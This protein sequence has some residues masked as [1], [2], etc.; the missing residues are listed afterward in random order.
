MEQGYKW[1]PYKIVTV[2]TSINGEI[3]WYKNK[4]KNFLLKIKRIFIKPKYLKNGEIYSKKKINSSYYGKI[5][6][7]GDNVL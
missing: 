1:I 2:A 6:I 7:N 3:V 5:N 4:W